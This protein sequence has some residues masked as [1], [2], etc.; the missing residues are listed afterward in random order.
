MKPDWLIEFEARPQPCEHVLNG[1]WEKCW[2]TQI[3]CD[4]HGPMKPDDWVDET[5][6]EREARLHRY[7]EMYTPRYRKVGCLETYLGHADI[8]PDR[9]PTVEEVLG[10]VL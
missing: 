7:L 1:D 6:E 2:C 5:G 3:E 4:G 10:F 8:S 9:I